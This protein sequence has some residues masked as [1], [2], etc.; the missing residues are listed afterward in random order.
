MIRRNTA[1]MILLL[2]PVFLGACSGLQQKLQ[3]DE[4]SITV[5]PWTSYQEAHKEFHD[6]FQKG[7]TVRSDLNNTKFDPEIMRN[8]RILS[9]FEIRQMLKSSEGQGVSMQ[10]VPAVIRECL[11]EEN[12]EE[13]VGFIYGGGASKTDGK[14]NVFLRAL[15]FKKEDLVTGWSFRGIA[16]FSG[17]TFVYRGWDGDPNKY[18]INKK[19]NPLGPL[20]G[21]VKT[22]IGLVL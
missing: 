10:D 22:G 18:I 16:L 11:R 17:Q 4:D 9:N 8:I 21:L 20:P 13:C 1:L 19:S 12:G 15:D 14:G 3:P 6:F 7:K 2:L 5:S